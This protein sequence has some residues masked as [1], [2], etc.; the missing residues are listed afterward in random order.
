MPAV[1]LPQLLLCGLFVPREALPTV[2]SAVSDALPLS[3]AVDAMQVLQQSSSWTSDLTVDVSV[4]VGSTVL[5]L[6]IGSVTLRR[7]TA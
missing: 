1:V 4:I 3:Y 6:A 7:Q 2:L 5:A